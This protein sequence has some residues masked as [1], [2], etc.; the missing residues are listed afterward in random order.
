MRLVRV[1]DGL[2]DI[3]EK[4]FHLVKDVRR[5][6]FAGFFDKVCRLLNIRQQRFETGDRLVWQVYANEVFFCVICNS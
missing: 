1:N 3:G 2:V 4:G 6:G 5:I